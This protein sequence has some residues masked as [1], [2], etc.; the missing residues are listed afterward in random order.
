MKTKQIALAMVIGALIGAF[1]CAVYIN[2]PRAHADPASDAGE[3]ICS[4]LGSANMDAEM[5]ILSS[6]LIRKGFAAKDIR[7]VYIIDVS[8]SCP[9]LLPRLFQWAHDPTTTGAIA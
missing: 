2:T 6:G 1:L 8:T 7:D 3:I 5:D 9:Q 4:Y